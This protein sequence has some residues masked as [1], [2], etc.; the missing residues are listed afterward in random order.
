METQDPCTE[1]QHIAHAVAKGIGQMAGV[2]MQVKPA[3]N[4]AT[5]GPRQRIWGIAVH[6]DEKALI[7]EVDLIATVNTQGSL[8]DVAAKIRRMVRHVT[9]EVT[10]THVRRIN[11]RIGN[12]RIVG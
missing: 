4:L 2:D 6:R 1:E 5:Y 3:T 11:I 9:K 7:I 12:L 10:P 8:P